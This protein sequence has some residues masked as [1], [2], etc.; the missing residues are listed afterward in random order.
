MRFRLKNML[1][2]IGWSFVRGKIEIFMVN[3]CV[4]RVVVDKGM[5]I[6][7]RQSVNEKTVIKSRWSLIGM[8]VHEEFHCSVEIQILFDNF[9]VS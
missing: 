8:V 9:T 1:P 4:C 7:R 2:R 6:Q 3:G 5:L